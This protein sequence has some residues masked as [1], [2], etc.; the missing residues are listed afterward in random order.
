MVFLLPSVTGC[1]WGFFGHKL[2][3]QQA[4]YSLPLPLQQIFLPHQDY[5]SIQAVDPDKR[6]YA[7]KEE[8]F[9]HYFDSEKWAGWLDSASIYDRPSLLES[10]GHFALIDSDTVWV[11]RSD[12]VFDSVVLAVPRWYCGT[13]W[14]YKEAEILDTMA[15]HGVLPIT[16]NRYYQKLIRAFESQ[17]IRECLQVAAELGHYIGDAHVPLHTTVNYNGQLTGQVG[18]HALWETH[19]PECLAEE[20]FDWAIG[21]ADFLKD[22]P[23][24]TWGI[25]RQSHEM[26]D[27]VLELERIVRH[28][29]AEE[30][31]SCFRE[32]SGS[33]SILPCEEFLKAYES[34][35]SH[36]VERQMRMSIKA[37]SSYWWSAYVEAG[38]PEMNGVRVATEETELP[39]GV[40]GVRCD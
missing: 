36:M 28:Q 17:D 15:L 22:V 12:P 33:M 31:E 26:V 29:F 20:T 13:S 23:S 3:N 14:D 19:V 5:L 24:R 10:I 8:A 38:Q 6:R 7:V 40:G 25:I 2:I 37:I 16:I 35:M 21:G 32:R 34:R 1:C 27:S 30:E 39:T 18:I 9:Q 4:V 11:D